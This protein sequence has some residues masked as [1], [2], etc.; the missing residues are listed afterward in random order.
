MSLVQ[1]LFFI[2]AKHNFTV[3]VKHIPG[4]NNSI[5]DALSR[6]QMA[7]FFKLAPSASPRGTL[8]P[9]QAWNI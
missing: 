3:N 9:P 1:K 2:A 7:K 4:T 5:A 8:I 6:L